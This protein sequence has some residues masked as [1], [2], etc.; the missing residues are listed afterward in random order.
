MSGP[1]RRE[2]IFAAAVLL[3]AAWRPALAIRANV[4]SSRDVQRFHLQSLFPVHKPAEYGSLRTFNSFNQARQWKWRARF[5]ARNGVLS[6]LVGG[7]AAPVSGGPRRAAFEFLSQNA[8][9]LGVDPDSLVL[10]KEVSAAGVAHLLFSQTYQG[11]PVE[12]AQVKM[13]VDS[14]G[15]VFNYHSSYEP[16]LNLGAAPSVPE[17]RAAQ[18]AVADAGGNAKASAGALVVWPN[19]QTGGDNL[20]WRVLVQSPSAAW[21][22]YIDANTGNILFR[23]DDYQ[24]VTEGGTIS[25]LVYAIDPSSTPASV[26]PFAHERVCAGSSAN[27]TTTDASGAYSG[28]AG[29]AEV[30]TTLQGSYVSVANFQGPN[31]HYENNGASWQI[32]STPL[33]SAHP[34]APYSISFATIN[35]SAL[36]PNAVE[37][38]PVFSEL[39]VGI[40]SNQGFSSSGS[41]GEAS[42][43]LQDDQ[44][45]AFD[46]FGNPIS[47]YVGTYSASFKGAMGVGQKMVLELN[48]AGGGS[49]GYGF[50]VATSSCLVLSNPNSSG[51]S[52]NLTWW[53]SSYTYNGMHSEISLYYQLNEMHDYFANTMAALGATG[54]TLKPTTALALVNNLTDAFYDPTHDD[55][56]FGDS[57]DSLPSDMFADDATVPHHEYTHYVVQKIWNI[58]NFGQA[59]AI[60]EAN[61]DYWSASSLGDPN[62]AAYVLQQLGYGYTPLREL[63]DNSTQWGNC[64]GSASCVSCSEGPHC[65]VLTSG[66]SNDWTGEIHTDSLFLSQALWDIRRHLLGASAASG[67]GCANQMEFTALLSYPESFGEF[68]DALDAA[69]QNYGSVSASLPACA[70]AGVSAGNLQGYVDN[71]FAAHGISGLSAGQ[72]FES[73]VDVSTTPTVQGSIATAG[74][75][76]FY[77]FGA[78]PG[79]VGITLTLPASPDGQ[80]YYSAYGITLFDRDHDVVADVQPTLN[81]VGTGFAGGVQVCSSQDCT[82]TQ[83]QVVLSYTNPSAN[84][85]YVRIAASPTGNNSNSGVNNSQP[86]TLMVSY[87]AAGAL[88]SQ[89]INASYDNDVISFDVATP[90]SGST[91]TYSFAYAQLRDQGQNIMAET[92]T[93]ENPSYLAVISTADASGAMSGK[94]QI[95]PGFAARYPAVG[96]VSVEIFGTDSLNDTVSFGLSDALNLAGNTTDMQAWNNVF[97]PLQGQKTTVKYQLQSPGHVSLK[98]YTLSGTLVET[99]LDSDEPAGQ[100]SVDWYGKNLRGSTVASGVYLLHINGPGISKTQKIVVVK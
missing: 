16:S 92:Q 2:T 33:S 94:L 27:C 3:L 63:D 20:A 39:N 23:Y 15:S 66:S 60:S 80:G 74:Q 43:I 62:I 5:S 86:Y 26:Q 85:F 71:A 4:E 68:Q 42:G 82:T 79:L 34:Y 30:F 59:G 56:F 78:G 58:Q 73:A 84:H 49:G 77:T 17:F 9:M 24:S 95:Q 93:N 47:D 67:V 13:D 65:D 37:F 32:V 91:P 96:S 76:N 87:S 57:L 22:Y 75:T 10:T 21:R 52:D 38:L 12:F 6:A 29:P 8:A 70:A 1:R 88:N 28:L 40:Y 31:A 11:L 83:Q 90:V 61:A 18:I 69:A 64:P 14:K 45:T 48:A 46:S 81:G 100:G 36:A 7:H 55:M 97:D 35:V 72:G 99:L 98:L 54:I 44:L 50:D 51:A 53:P 25:G 41:G 19:R 89:I